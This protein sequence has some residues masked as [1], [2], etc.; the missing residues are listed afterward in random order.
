MV[1]SIMQRITS[2]FY[3]FLRDVSLAVCIFVGL[4]LQITLCIPV[5]HVAD[6][7]SLQFVVL[8]DFDLRPCC[9]CVYSTF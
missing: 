3:L 7:Y 5:F 6:G 4:G 1:Y 9:L 2:G 8:S